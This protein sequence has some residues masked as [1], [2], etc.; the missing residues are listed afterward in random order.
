MLLSDRRTPKGRNRYHKQ[1]EN[2]QVHSKLHETQATPTYEP[3]MIWGIIVRRRL[4]D[5]LH[6]SKHSVLC[7]QYRHGLLPL[8]FITHTVIDSET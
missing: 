7:E 8:D 2:C 5:K 6:Q 3:P 1:Y 4:S